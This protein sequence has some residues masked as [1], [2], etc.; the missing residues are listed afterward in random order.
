MYGGTS[1][2]HGIEYE[3]LMEGQVIEFKV[4]LYVNL[5]VGSYSVATAL[6]R[7]ASHVEGNIEWKDLNLLFDV[8]NAKEKK[9]IGLSWLE[10]EMMSKVIS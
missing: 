4:K 3:N 2:D 8:I 10:D 6:S 1:L 9:F 7:G 5:G